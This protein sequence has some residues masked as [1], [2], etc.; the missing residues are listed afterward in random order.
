[1]PLWLGWLPTTAVAVAAGVVGVGLAWAWASDSYNAGVAARRLA[2]NERLEKPLPEGVVPGGGR[3]WETTAPHLVQWAAY[4]DKVA[5]DPERAREAREILFRAQQVSPLNTTV[6][7]AVARILPGE[8]PSPESKLAYG[9]GQSRDVLTL[10]WA[11][12]RLLEAGHKPAALLAYRAA[13]DMAGQV[14]PARPEA[15]AFLETEQ[16]R[17]YAVP[18]EERLA[19]VIRAM[20]AAPEW[21]YE[22]WAGAIPPRTA[23]PLATARVLR[24]TGNPAATTAL[25]VAVKEAESEP[26]PVI[27][28]LQPTSDSDEPD[29]T[30]YIA[31]APA[32][33][34]RLAAG[35]AA[36]AM[37]QH[38]AAARDR[39]RRAIDRAGDDS[40]R[41]ACWVN[42]SDLSLRLEE[43]SGRRLALDAAKN[44]DP[45]D[46]I[47]RRAVELQ[48]ASGFMAQR[49]QS[50]GPEPPNGP[51]R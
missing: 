24:E 3:W 9:L 14:D 51:P 39:Y 25:D 48:K 16:P 2:A 18:T 46:E 32:D 35:A 29:A 4:L 41:R 7:H 20:A 13:L 19:V 1:M 26:L 50:R 34:V 23:A 31:P 43:E 45:K 27:V 17:R 30:P 42:V 21:T 15:P 33:A 28:S 22:E 5:D 37:K 38:W 10:T 49:T 36:L 40:V 11:G 47:T 6:R 8:S 44:A 12:R